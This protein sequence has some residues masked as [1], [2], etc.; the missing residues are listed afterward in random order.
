MRGLHCTTNEA[1]RLVSLQAAKEELLARQAEENRYWDT[2][3]FEEA[4]QK[5][6][7]RKFVVRISHPVDNAL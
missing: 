7:Y 4:M 3:R 1:R 5:V 2:L 6:Q